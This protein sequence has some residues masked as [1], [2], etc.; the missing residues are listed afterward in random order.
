MA[1][2]GF[3]IRNCPNF[4]IS[5][6]LLLL[7]AKVH[8]YFMLIRGKYVK[9][10]Y[11]HVITFVFVFVNFS[12]F[13]ED[14]LFYVYLLESCRPIIVMLIDFY[15]YFFSLFFIFI[16]YMFKF[17]DYGFCFCELVDG[18]KFGDCGHMV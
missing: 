15:F 12:V 13:L 10:T 16:L 6:L 14:N 7:C 9:T 11:Y 17:C 2:N 1:F 3:N 18:C 8:I 4:Y 5:R